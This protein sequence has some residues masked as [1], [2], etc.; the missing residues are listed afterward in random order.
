MS[1]EIAETGLKEQVSVQFCGIPNLDG[2]A[3]EVHDLIARRAYA[4]YEGRGHASGHDV[5][6]WLQAESE[7]VSPVCVGCMELN[8]DLRIDV[9]IEKSELPQLQ[10][11][12]E[13]SR[14]I[15]SGKRAAERTGEDARGHPGETPRPVEIFQAVNLP[16]T[17]EPAGARATFVNGLLELLVPKAA[18]TETC[19]AA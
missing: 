8:R 6:D 5:Q 3:R 11:S 18:N 14:L 10:V 9:G 7:V 17:V 19:L 15:I 16:C 4:I 2:R 1:W 13:P 12:I